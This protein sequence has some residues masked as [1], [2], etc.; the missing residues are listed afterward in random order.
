MATAK[1][2]KSGKQLKKS[3]KL[4]ATTP[5]LAPVPPPNNIMPR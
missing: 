5:L 1:A 3:K 4:E 2:R